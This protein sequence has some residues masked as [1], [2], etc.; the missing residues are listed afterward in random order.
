M[1]LLI[2]QIITSYEINIPIYVGLLLLVAI[3]QHIGQPCVVLIKDCNCWNNSLPIILGRETPS[4]QYVSSSRK[5]T[6]GILHPKYSS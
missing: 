1:F 3:V 5:I 6:E 2:I 4:L